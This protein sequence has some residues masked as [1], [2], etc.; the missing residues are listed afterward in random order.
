MAACRG[1]GLQAR[2]RILAHESLRDRQACRC[3]NPDRK[4]QAGRVIISPGVQGRS[5]RAIARSL[6]GWAPSRRSGIGPLLSTGGHRPVS[7]N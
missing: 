7:T 6:P 2:A 4:G 3:L 1:G 5:V